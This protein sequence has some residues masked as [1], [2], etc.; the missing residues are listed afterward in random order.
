MR[1]DSNQTGARQRELGLR[2]RSLRRLQVTI[3]SI[4]AAEESAVKS[5]MDTVRRTAS[6]SLLLPSAPGSGLPLNADSPALTAL[7][8]A[9]GTLPRFCFYSRRP[10]LR[11]SV[12]CFLKPPFTPN[13]G[14]LPWELRTGPDPTAARTTSLVYNHSV[15]KTRAE[16][17]MRAPAAP[18]APLSS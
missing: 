14:A 11:A 9:A 7:A 4:Q 1:T 15:P 5:A 17:Q 16:R 2:N 3:L 18:P 12:L 6:A 8:T 13:C 10:C